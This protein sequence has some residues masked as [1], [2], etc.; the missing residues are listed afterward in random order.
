MTVRGAGRRH[1]VLQL[2]RLGIRD[3]EPTREE[4]VSMVVRQAC[5]GLSR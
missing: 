3:C 4:R 1:L 2:E 5:I